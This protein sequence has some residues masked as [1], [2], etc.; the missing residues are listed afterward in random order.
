MGHKFLKHVER[1]KQLLFVVGDSCDR[2]AK[3][4]DVCALHNN[5]IKVAFNDLLNLAAG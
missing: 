4:S 3:L 2:V 1:T 5:H